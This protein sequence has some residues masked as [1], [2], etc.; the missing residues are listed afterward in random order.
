MNSTAHQLTSYERAML[1]TLAYTDQFDHPLT[2]EELLARCLRTVLSDK[3]LPE[4]KLRQAV[5]QLLKHR[6]IDVEVDFGTTYY[7]LAGRAGLVQRRKERAIVA[8]KKSAEVQHAVTFLKSIPSIQAIYL[9]G[10]QAMEGA[11]EQSDI[12]FMI[13]TSPRRLWMTR[14][15]V[16]I[17]AQLQGKRRSWNNEEAGSWCFNLW[18]DTDHL[19]V[20][21]SKQDTYRAY[22]VLQAQELWSKNLVGSAFADE[23]NWIGQHFFIEQKNK[24]KRLVESYDA[25]ATRTSFTPS[26]IDGIDWL[27]WKL[28]SLYMKRHQTIEK[29]GRGFAFFH[30]RETG[31][32]IKDGWFASLERCLPKEMATEILQPYVRTR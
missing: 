19:Q 31:N 11:D 14:I 23:N 22:E 1:V 25:R 3:V 18:L 16:S 24:G 7:F 20:Q 12:D 2:S 21:S 30:P 5:A 6:L 26:V 27:A 4:K 8:H 9:T 32:M 29:V 28:Q 17:F 15:M 13:I 10:S